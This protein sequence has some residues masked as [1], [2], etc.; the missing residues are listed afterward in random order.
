MTLKSEYLVSYDYHQ[1]VIHKYK[2]TC[3]YWYM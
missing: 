3:L 1:K 2:L